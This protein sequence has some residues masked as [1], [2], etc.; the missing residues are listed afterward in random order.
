MPKIILL[1][2]L[3]LISTISLANND[4]NQQIIINNYNVRL[5]TSIWQRIQGGFGLEHDQTP[6]VQYYE[7][8]Y[9]KNPA[10]FRQMMYRSLPYIYYILTQ[11]ERLGL[12]SELALIP[13]VETSFNNNV[14][15][16][17]WQFE[18]PTATRFGLKII[19][20]H[21]DQ[22]KN[23]VLATNM[24]LLYFVYLYHLF[25]NWQVA[26]GAYNWGEGN[27]YNAIKASGQNINN[28]SYHRLHLRQ[29]TT[30]YLPKLI[31][32][33]TIISN[34]KHFGVE[35][36][37]MLNSPYFKLV[38]PLY[39]MSVAEFIDVSNISNHDFFSLNPQFKSLAYSLTP[40][41]RILVHINYRNLQLNPNLSNSTG[42]VVVN[43]SDGDSILAQSLLSGDSYN[44]NNASNSNDNE[45]KNKIS[46]K[47]DLGAFLNNLVATK[48]NDNESTVIVVKHMISNEG[49]PKLHHIIYVRQ[50]KHHSKRKYKSIKVIKHKP[51]S[52]SRK[53]LTKHP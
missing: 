42:S 53:K 31:A 20:N 33:A 41:D 46:D 25:N 48:S 30:N 23:V 35:L 18:I 24:A 2:V 19:P 6:L 9:T 40:H 26:I 43:A 14:N 45:A 50:P 29:I 11:V 16:G 17:L 7:H 27:M 10:S 3:I 22:R 32:L 36:P 15:S 52:F 34:P 39:S 51:K 47:D 5:S 44:D 12:P 8:F 28:I 49:K 37:Y 4:L 38:H 13:A 21:L 1:F